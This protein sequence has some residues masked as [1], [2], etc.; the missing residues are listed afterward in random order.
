MA[1]SYIPARA[2]LAELLPM[3]GAHR[4]AI[5][6]ALADVPRPQALDE[7]AALAIVGIERAA[8]DRPAFR[9]TVRAPD[10]AKPT[11]FA[12]G[13]ENWYLSTSFPAEGNSFVVT[14]ED[15]PK[16]ASGPVPVRLTLVAGDDA[17]ETE[18]RLDAGQQPR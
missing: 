14:V 2:E 11:L 5:A 9:V 12:E 1:S 10:G 13:P 16:D 7:K 3:V 18:V 15:Q 8:Q 6:E 17:I 4:A